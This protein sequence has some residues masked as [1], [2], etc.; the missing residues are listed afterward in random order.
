MFSGTE[1]ALIEECK[2]IPGRGYSDRLDTRFQGPSYKTRHCQTDKFR[3]FDSR[4]DLRRVAAFT[5]TRRKNAEIPK[6]SGT[7]TLLGF[8]DGLQKALNAGEPGHF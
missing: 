3:L 8:V 1:I 4:G 7:A 2:K 6:Y 5:L